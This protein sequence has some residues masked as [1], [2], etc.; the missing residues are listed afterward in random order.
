MFAKCVASPNLRAL[1]RFQI[2]SVDDRH[3]QKPQ[4]AVVECHHTLVQGVYTSHTGVHTPETL[5]TAYSIGNSTFT[6]LA[7][8]I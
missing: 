3:N 2:S 4:L 6:E 1:S 8:I 7:N 5:S